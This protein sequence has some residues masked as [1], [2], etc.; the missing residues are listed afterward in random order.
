MFTATGTLPRTPRRSALWLS[1]LVVA[2]F[3]LAAFAIMTPGRTDGAADPGIVLP[4]GRSFAFLTGLDAEGLVVDQAALLTGPEAKAAAIED[5]VLA[6][7][8]E[9]P[10]GFYI[11]NESDAS[12]GV[13]IAAD[14]TYSV[15]MFDGAGSLVE[16]EIDHDQLMALYVDEGASQKVYGFVPE[17]FPVELVVEDGVITGFEQVYLP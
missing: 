8:D 7:G 11:R 4:D 2:T 12:A 9:L 1:L 17:A 14:V 3:A 6:E 15:L 13:K 16:T 5:G 10:Y